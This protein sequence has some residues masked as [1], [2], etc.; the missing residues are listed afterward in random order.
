VIY[1]GFVGPSYVSQAFPADNEDL[2]NWYM[3]KI[4]SPGAAA[5]MAFCPTPGI[6]SI[7][8]TAGT[9][10]RAHYFEAATGRE[11]AIVSNLLFEV[12]SDGVASFLGFVAV[13]SNPATISSNGDGGGQLF[14]TSGGNG[15]I[16]DLATNVLTQVAALNGIATMGAAI[17]GYFLA[18]DAAT[19][20]FYASDLLDGLTWSTGTMFAQRNAAPDPWVAMAV[21]GPYIYLFGSLTME[22]WFNSGS[23]PFP[24]AK[25]PSGLSQ[26]GIAAPFSWA[27]CDTSLVWLGATRSG[28]G[29]VL[30]ASGFT[31]EVVSTYPVQLAMGGYET[32]SDAYGDSYKEAGHTF[33]VLSFP[34]ANVT[35]AFDLQMSQW[36]KRGSWDT[37]ANAFSVWRPRCHAF[38]YGEHR[39]LDLKGGAV[40]RMSLDIVRDVAEGSNEAILIRRLR[41]APAI[42]NENKRVR[43]VSLEV[44]L[45]VG[46]GLVESE[47]GTPVVMMRFSNDGGKTWSEEQWKSAGKRGQYNT[48]VRFTRLGT[49]RRRVFEIVV[50][51]ETRW[52]MTNA[53]LETVALDQSEAA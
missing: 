52:I 27:V 26:W 13:D 1:R 20:T 19:G 4:E 29:F 35:W 5:R 2:V 53:W 34:T 40:F 36:A 39:W 47:E 9:Q 46:V 30:R 50:S 43:Y 48:R 6:E 10:G 45:E 25:H 7:H 3:E 42:V 21:L 17:D 14:I 44:E 41:R 33:Y 15:Y 22:I 37:N 16:L 31:P 51:D 49:A 12:D 8:I 24:F 38:A 23:S 11:I 28:R 32:V 18:L